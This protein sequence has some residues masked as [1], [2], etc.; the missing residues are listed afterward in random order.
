MSQTGAY[1]L[2]PLS[3]NASDARQLS[4]R[5]QPYVNQATGSDTLD[6]GRG[7]SEEKPF[8]TIQAAVNYV[9]ENYNVS[10]YT[11][12]IYIEP[13]YDN[14]ADLELPSYSAS[15]GAIRIVS[16]SADPSQCKVRR[17]SLSYAVPYYLWNITARAFSIASGRYGC[18]HASKGQLN[19]QNCVADMTS[20]NI[21]GGAF[22]ACFAGTY[23]EI[24]IWALTENQT[25]YFNVPG[26]KIIGDN[27][28]S[29]DCIFNADSGGLISFAADIKIEGNCNITSA[30][31]S[32]SNLS[33]ILWSYSSLAI[34][35]RA[36]VITISEDSSVSGK[37]YS[38]SGNS[39]VT[40]RGQGAEAYPGT[41]VGTTTNGGQ[42]Y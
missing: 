16:K 28:H 22:S 9:C 4:C 35:G 15:T 39:I 38:S 17:I 2:Q 20:A 8:K 33:M 37:R 24:R 26:I 23:G 7:E 32:A 3:Y 30:F 5:A 27:K 1:E 25:D 29:F 12:T 41:I 19:L 10:R 14:L 34:P 21:S 6:S 40:A 42:Y 13:P 11:L 36:P 18:F 31:A